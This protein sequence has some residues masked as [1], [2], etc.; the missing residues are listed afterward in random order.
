MAQAQPH[1][2]D[3]ANVLEYA[4]VEEAVLPNRIQRC[5]APAKLQA[6]PYRAGLHAACTRAPHAAASLCLLLPG[7]R[8]SRGRSAAE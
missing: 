4:G 5:V 6:R 1:A 2:P 7:L 3:K 8:R